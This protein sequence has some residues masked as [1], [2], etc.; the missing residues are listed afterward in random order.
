VLDGANLSGARFS[1]T[2]LHRISES[3]AVIP[4]RRGSFGTDMERYRAEHWHQIDDRNT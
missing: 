1:R 2:N 3:E 4:S